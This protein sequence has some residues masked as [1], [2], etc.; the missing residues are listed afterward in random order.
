MD[1]TRHR[2]F[3]MLLLGLLWLAGM[4]LL[5]FCLVKIG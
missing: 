2:W 1:F 3:F 4:S 5:V